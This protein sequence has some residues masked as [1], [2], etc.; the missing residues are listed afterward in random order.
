VIFFFDR[1]LDPSDPEKLEKA[2][3][4]IYR[5][6]LDKL[7]G[8]ANN[9]NG[10]VLEEVKTTA[11]GIA[12]YLCKWD[13]L[14]RSNPWG[15]ESEIMMSN[16]KRG[17]FGSYGFF[18]LVELAAAGVDWAKE[19]VKEYAKATK[20][21]RMLGWS[22]GLRSRLLLPLELTDLEIA[23]QEIGQAS[24]IA[25]VWH[26][27]KSLGLRGRFLDLAEHNPQELL[28]QISILESLL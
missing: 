11:D 10:F 13:H 21:V 2:V 14:P 15:V 1:L 18:E 4:E 28:N 9:E 12:E 8:Y 19:K 23:T 20:G 16:F 7:G 24:E 26:L 5:R 6:K 27:V 17:K 22:R 25:D 3:R